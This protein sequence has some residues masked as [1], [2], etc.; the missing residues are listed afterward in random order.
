MIDLHCHLLPGMDDGPRDLAESLALA[1]IACAGGIRKA[2][3]TPHIYPG[4]YD[5]DIAAIR[6]ATA[7]FK[8]A[9]KA[10]HIPLSVEMAAEVRIGPEIMPMIKKELIP[11]LGREGEYRILLLEFPHSHI[12]LGSNKMAQWLLD[13][14]IRP[15]IAHP[16]RNKDILRNFEKI[17]PFVEL[18]CL[19]QITGGSVAGYFGPAV[20]QRARQLLEKGWVDVLASDAHNRDSRPPDLASGKAAAAEIVGEKMAWSLVRE[21]PWEIVKERFDAIS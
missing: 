21:R 20:Q 1:R 19:M 9:L 2:L 5:N 14:K 7:E 6:T 17:Y 12:P 10:H 15:M 11:F 13:R 8:Q 3:A 18:G 16:E 4:V